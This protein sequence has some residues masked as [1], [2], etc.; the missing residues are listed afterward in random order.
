MGATTKPGRVLRDRYRILER[1]GQGG[2]GAVYQA[3]DLRLPGRITA[4]KEIHLDLAA[5]PEAKSDVQEQ[6][7]EEPS[8]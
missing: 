3:E 8:F 1:V 5:T 4:V 2:A 6:L 7:S